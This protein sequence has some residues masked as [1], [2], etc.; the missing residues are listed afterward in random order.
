M[1]KMEIEQMEG[2]QG[3]AWQD[4]FWMVAGFAG[5]MAASATW[6]GVGFAVLSFAGGVRSAQA[7]ADR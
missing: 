7:C 6:V 4:C 3:G 2:I 5:A 1:K